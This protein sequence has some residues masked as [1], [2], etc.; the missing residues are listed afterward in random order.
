MIVGV[1][2]ETFP[3]ERRVALIPAHVPGLKKA[4]FDVVVESGAGTEAGFVDSAYEEKGAEIVGERD[5]VFSRADLVAVVRGVGANPDAGRD[6]LGRI[7]EG[8]MLLGFCD[9][10]S[11]PESVKAFAGRKASLFAMEMMPRTTR[12]QSMDALS[13]MNSLAGY[14]AVLLAAEM[15][16]KI[17]PLM[18]TAAGTLAP[19]KVFVVGAGVAGLQAIATARRLGA[20]ITA[21]DVRA[22]VREQVESLG[23]RF[24]DLGFEADASGQ[25]GYA[26]EQTE[27]E[28]RRQQE[29]MAK[30][31]AE[32]DVVITTAAVP[33][34][35]APRI[36]SAAM[37]SGMAPGSVVVDIAAERG[38]NCELTRPGETIVESG[39]RIA[40]PQNVAADVPYHASQAYSKNVSNFL[41]HVFRNGDGPNLEDEITSSTLV[42]HRGEVR[43]ESVRKALGP[44]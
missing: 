35:K 26:R 19:A 11:D 9:P 32:S 39:V 34:R 30:I 1:P 5:A 37:V 36:I 20:L 6:D 23:A 38:G 40:G 8:Q 14:R 41:T 16:P 2:R 22:V 42:V 10:L 4:G 43:D 3:G 15:L 29:A 7:R 12:A 28:I 25:G 13:S 18:M 44:S 27:E 24:A 21:Y 17:F 33:G 31:V